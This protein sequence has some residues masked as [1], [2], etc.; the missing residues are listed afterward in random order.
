MI[1][2]TTD[3]LGNT[4]SKEVVSLQ[5]KVTRAPLPHE[6]PRLRLPLRL[7]A[8]AKLELERLHRPAGLTP[9][10]REA[11]LLYHIAVH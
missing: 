9:C 4:H 8:L 3:E 1:E 10:L 11:E 7:L 6:Q 2:T 5:G